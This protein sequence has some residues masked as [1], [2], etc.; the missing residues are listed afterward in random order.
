M[1]QLNLPPI[2]PKTILITVINIEIALGRPVL[3]FTLLSPSISLLLTALFRSQSSASV[4][5]SPSSS[6]CLF[7]NLS[8]T[9]SSILP[10]SGAEDYLFD[11]RHS[12]SLVKSDSFSTS[13]GP[14]L[15]IQNSILHL[16]TP[17]PT[18]HQPPRPPLPHTHWWRVL[19]G[20]S[21]N[22]VLWASV[23]R[24]SS[25]AA[26]LER[27]LH[28]CQEGWSIWGPVVPSF[29]SWNTSPLTASVFTVRPIVLALQYF[30]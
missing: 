5:L 30:Q 21:P 20:L 6:C 11:S 12:I 18:T 3:Y 2:N 7:F 16:S 10:S 25:C 17:T 26:A 9:S 29:H 24:M 28:L 1:W 15:L 23:C 4:S 19:T 13:I 22:L 27:R 8:F 14:L